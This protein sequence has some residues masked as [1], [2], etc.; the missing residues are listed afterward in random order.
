MFGQEIHF[1]RNKRTMYFNRVQVGYP[2]YWPSSANRTVSLRGGQREETN[3]DNSGVPRL[4]NVCHFEPARRSHLHHNWSPLR[5]GKLLFILY[6]T[7][8]RS[9]M[10]PSSVARMFSVD[11]RETLTTTTPMTS[12]T[13]RRP[14]PP[15]YN[16]LS[17]ETE[18]PTRSPLNIRA[19]RARLAS[20]GRRVPGLSVSSF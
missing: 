6:T 11:W 2:F 10:C 18:Q 9:R 14:Y 7:G 1:D 16:V 15:V 8:C 19:T 12:P 3:S 17:L 20:I 5:H 4:D 13:G